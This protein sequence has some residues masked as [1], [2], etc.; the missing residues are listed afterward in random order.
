MRI[1]RKD[2]VTKTIP[3]LL[4]DEVDHI[5]GKTGLTP[6]V[7]IS[8]NGAPF[9]AP[10]G[11]VSELGHGWYQ[12]RPAAA[13]VDTLGPLLLHAEAAGADPVDIEFQVVAFDVYSELLVL[14]Q[15]LIARVL[16][17][18]GDG[19]TLTFWAAAKMRASWYLDQDVS[20]HDLAFLIYAASDPNTALAE[21]RG[22]EITTTAQEKGCLVALEASEQKLPPPGAYRFVLRDQ[23]TDSV[24]LSG[25]VRVLAAPDAS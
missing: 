9:A 15:P 6:T 22:D 12:L 4:C 17:P 1:L 24:L 3:F 21:C 18:D 23:T 7:R 25:A 10:V 20:G 8:K 11:T 16:T 2:D 14:V 13:D 5:T 19:G